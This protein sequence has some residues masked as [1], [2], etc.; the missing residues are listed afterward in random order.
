MAAELQDSGLLALA[1]RHLGMAA[2]RHGDRA[3]MR[4]ALEAA[5]RAARAAGDRREEAFALIS[6]GAAA[7]QEGAAQ[8]ADLLGQG[9]ALASD[10]GDAGPVG[11]AQLVLGSIEAEQGRHAEAT[12]LTA[13]ALARARPMGYWAVMVGSLA[14][15][16]ALA[17][18]QGDLAAARRYA[19]ECVAV[20]RDAADLGLIAAALTTFA[21]LELHAGDAEQAV[22]LL[23]AESAWRAAS[24]AQRAVSFWTWRAPTPE[25]ARAR[26]GEAAFGLAWAAGQ[27]LT[28]WQ[29]IEDALTAQLTVAPS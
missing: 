10:V 29:A 1:Q 22:R 13:D 26:L 6:I 2:R 3:A 7:H 16:S 21:E 14:Q 20:A 4:E 12:R 24:G 11:W 27:R 5:L 23:A 25:E 19:R 17:R 18:A 8:A 28:L 9:L 15:L